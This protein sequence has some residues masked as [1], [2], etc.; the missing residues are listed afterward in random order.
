MVYPGETVASPKETALPTSLN[1][2]RPGTLMK[3]QEWPGLTQEWDGGLATGL[4]GSVGGAC[5]VQ[6]S[7]LAPWKHVYFAVY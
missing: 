1:V 3:Q 4:P 2:F 6:N 7:W 5:F